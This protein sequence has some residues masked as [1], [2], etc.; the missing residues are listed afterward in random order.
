MRHLPSS[1]TCFGALW[2]LVWVTA[3]CGASDPGPAATLRFSGIPDSDKEKL[4][5]QYEVVTSYLSDE[6]GMPV[7]FVFAS[8]YTAAVTALA[9]NKVDL[10]WLGGVTSVQ[11]EEQTGGEVTFVATRV[12][13]LE[14]QSYFIAN[15]SLG[16]EPVDSLEDLKTVLGEHTFTFG[17][18]SSTSGH[19]MPRYFMTQAGISP[20]DDTKGGAKFQLQ[21]G[22][23]ATL[24]VVANGS[25]DI[26]A[27]NYKTWLG[28]GA[29][30]KAKAP[31][32]YETPPYV[33]YCMVAHNRLGA[34]R[35]AAIRRAFTSL[36]PTVP[37]H[38]E[39]LEAFEAAKF[40]AAE[41]EDWDGIRKVLADP[42]VRSAMR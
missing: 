9:A 11:A 5:Q 30:T 21:G 26:G 42:A 10:V 3:S 39:V 19:I 27:L 13:D 40:V 37:E 41:S 35:I 4:Q 6:I 23:S 14:F 24:R 33:D 15:A 38:A 22:H 2:L 18:K 7:E 32:I 16:L 20:E 8:D 29:A 25:T 34:D 12:S 1:C 36:D 31:V 17:S 28:T